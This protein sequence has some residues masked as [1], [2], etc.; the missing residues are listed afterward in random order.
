MPYVLAWFPMILI[1]VGNGILR[2]AT[3]GKRMTE[4]AAHQCSTVIGGVL[5]G[6]Y[7]GVVIWLLPPRSTIQAL[8]V[9]GGWMLATVMFEFGFGR[10]VAGHSWTRISLKSPVRSR[11]WPSWLEIGFAPTSAHRCRRDGEDESEGEICR[12]A[13]IP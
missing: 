2:G 11:K 9:G 5:L 1:G 4:L 13:N 3:Y 7:I 10:L 12:R 8:A 6:L